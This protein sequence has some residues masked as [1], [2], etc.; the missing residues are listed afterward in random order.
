M[1][2]RLHW[3][4]AAVVLGAMT[5]VAIGFALSSWRWGG[6]DV[7]IL[8][9]AGDA[10][11]WAVLGAAAAGVAVFGAIRLLPRGSTGKARPAPRTRTRTQPP[12]NLEAANANGR[13]ARAS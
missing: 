1:R 8:K 7:W 5:G 6:F 10:M 2:S 11:G 4:P 3:I 12:A 9:R 13:L